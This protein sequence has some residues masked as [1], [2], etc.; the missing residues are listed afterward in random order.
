MNILDKEITS[1]EPLYGFEQEYTMLGSDGRVF[2]W[3]EGGYPA[4]QGPFYCGA[5]KQSSPPP[6]LA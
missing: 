2:G 6:S 4:P 5:G 3:P 1:E